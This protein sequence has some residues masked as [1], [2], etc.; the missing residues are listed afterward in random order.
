M[1]V[2]EEE[3]KAPLAN[4]NT[5]FN[6]QATILPRNMQP[7][8]IKKWKSKDS[9]STKGGSSTPKSSSNKEKN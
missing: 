5:L 2:N 3:E 9:K 4:L 7:W 1:E 8:E 6:G